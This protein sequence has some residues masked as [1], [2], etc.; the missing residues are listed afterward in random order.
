MVVCILYHEKWILPILNFNDKL[1][2]FGNYVGFHVQ[3]RPF[4]GFVYLV[5]YIITHTCTIC[6]DCYHGVGVFVGVLFLSLFCFECLFS[7][8]YT[9]SI[10]FFFQLPYSLTQIEHFHFHFFHI[11]TDQLNGKSVCVVIIWQTLEVDSRVQFGTIWDLEGSAN[12]LKCVNPFSAD[13]TKKS[14]NRGNSLIFLD[15]KL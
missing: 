6:G 10:L 5:L 14:W 3:L 12:E 8:A 13:R 15:E 4:F 1:F 11:Q 2:H 9:L 7:K